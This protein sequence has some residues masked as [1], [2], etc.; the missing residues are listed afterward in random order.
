M[1]II[2]NMSIREE[3]ITKIQNLKEKYGLSDRAISL[4]ATKDH[5]AAKKL[6]DGKHLTLD[7]CELLKS[8]VDNYTPPN[9]R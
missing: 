3:L 4:G 9:I 7:T 8:F 1:L 2:L 5:R 6:R